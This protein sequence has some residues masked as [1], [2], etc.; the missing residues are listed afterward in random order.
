MA[1]I[2]GFTPRPLR[3]T[4]VSST[5]WRVAAGLAAGRWCADRAF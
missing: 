1:F 4:E 3:L 2:D 5:L